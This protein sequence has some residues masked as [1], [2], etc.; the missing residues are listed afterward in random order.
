MQKQLELEMEDSNN[1]NKKVMMGCSLVKMQMIVDGNC[2]TGDEDNT[3]SNNSSFIPEKL[4]LP[5]D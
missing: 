3:T 5:D 1:K 4:I 2:C